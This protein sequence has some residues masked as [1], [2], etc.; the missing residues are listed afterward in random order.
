MD[1]AQLYLAPLYSHHWTAVAAEHY[2]FGIGHCLLPS[3]AKWTTSLRQAPGY[4]IIQEPG[5]RFL[6]FGIQQPTPSWANLINTTQ[7]HF[8]KYLWLA[9]FP[10]LMIFVTISSV[11]YR[12]DGLGD[13][14]DP[15]KVL[16]KVGEYT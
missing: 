2:L 16:K 12:G 7:D 6:G 15:Y 10:G 8:L 4:A 11:N 9:I 5:L 3:C 13:A 1:D 14:L